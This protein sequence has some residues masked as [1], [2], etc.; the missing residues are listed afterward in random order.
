MKYNSLEEDSVATGC[1]V[2]S[3][4]DQ[5]ILVS[6]LGS[7]VGV[8]IIDEVEKIAGMYHILLSR[9]A[10]N[11]DTFESLNYASV[12]M[13]EFIETF[14]KRGSVKENLYAVIAGGAL[15]GQVSQLD[16]ELDTGG[17]TIDVVT[18][19]LNSAGIKLK[20]EISGGYFSTRF[21][22]NL[23][24]YEYK[25]ES[26][27]ENITDR[28]RIIE[29][30]QEIDFDTAISRIS[31]IP[32]IALKIIRLI[33]ST[34]YNMKEIANEIRND[35]VVGA[36]IL[37]LSNS[38]FC[39]MRK[40]IESIDQA[41][42]LIGEKAIL[43]F[44][45]QSSI[46]LFF[47]DIGKGY[48]L[49]KSGLYYHAMAA[50]RFSEFIAQKTGRVKP[51]IAYTA[52]L[53]HDIGKVVLDQYIAH[54]FPTFF[55]RIVNSEQNIIDIEENLVGINHA[56]AGERLAK[57]WNLPEIIKETIVSHHYPEKAVQNPELAHIVYIADLILSRY[58]TGNELEKINTNNFNSRL[59]RL[60]LNS[61]SFSE[62]INYLPWKEISAIN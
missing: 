61:K 23:A 25:V 15:L 6:H 36:K 14:Y 33:N 60:G 48:S 45:L 52:G 9:P 12:G 55:D 53:L 59:E 56:I 50:A 22:L 38:A 28:K 46:D 54:V 31:P 5:K 4:V 29:M 10:S 18:S 8:I 43:K 37:Q 27:G 41:L 7:C 17:R 20:K 42:V 30:S 16:M 32:Q 51:D 35:Q 19:I 13:P 58:N 47:Q 40:K 1:F 57:I 44:V 24:N 49:T 11:N 34:D 3:G 26:I 21:S 2:V 62:M 39:G